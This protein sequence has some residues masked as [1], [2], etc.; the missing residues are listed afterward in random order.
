MSTDLTSIMQRDCFSDRSFEI[1]ENLHCAET[2]EDEKEIA[3]IINQASHRLL[4]KF[5]AQTPSPLNLHSIEIPSAVPEKKLKRFLNLLQNIEYTSHFFDMVKKDYDIN[6]QNSKYESLR[7]T[8]DMTYNW[9]NGR[10]LDR[11]GVFASVRTLFSLPRNQRIPH[12]MDTLLTLNPQDILCKNL[13]NL[14]KA[15]NSSSFVAEMEKLLNEAKFSKVDLSLTTIASRSLKN[16]FC[17]HPNQD[18]P[19][20]MRIKLGNQEALVWGIADG[21]GKIPENQEKTPKNTLRVADFIAQNLSKVLENL[22][23]AFLPLCSQ[24]PDI[25]L[26]NTLK[27]CGVYLDAYHK[28]VFPDNL[29]DGA[30]LCFCLTTP[31]LTYFVNIGDSR[32]LILD[33]KGEA[34]QMTLDATGKHQEFKNSVIKREGYIA[35]LNGINRVNGSLMPFRAIGDHYLK[36]LLSNSPSGIDPLD[37]RAKVTFVPTQWLKENHKRILIESDGVSGNLINSEIN[38]VYEKNADQSLEFFCDEL[39]N[40]QCGRAYY[41]FIR[42]EMDY[43]KL[44]DISLETIINSPD[45]INSILDKI[46]DLHPIFTQVWPPLKDA[47]EKKKLIQDACDPNGIGYTDDD[48]T[49]ISLDFMDPSMKAFTIEDCAEKKMIYLSNK[50]LASMKGPSVYISKKVIVQ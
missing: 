23:K 31:R 42:K 21:H 40:I 29:N 11:L 50:D 37:K 9:P 24:D 18:V 46:H 8:I 35:N 13:S 22:Y 19:F 49:I 33:A 30:C 39:L 10:D 38:A 32:A 43:F 45:L 12:V 48:M 6:N 2:I 28:E 27:L 17:K 7:F 26:Y 5:T 36:K 3:D 16:F 14:T 25:A 44:A 41:T 20:E 4:P 1:D 15:S 47:Q 34:I